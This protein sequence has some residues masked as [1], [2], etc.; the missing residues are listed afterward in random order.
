MKNIY[1]GN[2]SFATTET[3]LR[4]VFEHYGAVQNI[5]L[6]RHEYT[7]KP[8]GFAFVEMP[9]DSQGLAAITAVNG[10][11]LGGRVLVVN[12][13]RPKRERDPRDGNNQRWMPRS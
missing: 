3:E 10:S 1:V 12:E 9:D 13:A 5:N 8:L 4:E 2:F 11:Q 7:G 6:I